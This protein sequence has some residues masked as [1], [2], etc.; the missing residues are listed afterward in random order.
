MESTS[1]RRSDKS[2]ENYE[3]VSSETMKSA[4]VDDTHE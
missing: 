1:G 3:F 2:Y 4:Q